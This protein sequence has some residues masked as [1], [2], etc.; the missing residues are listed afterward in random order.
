MSTASLT[1]ITDIVTSND[2][3]S[4]SFSVYQL[5]VNKRPDRQCVSWALSCKMY[6]VQST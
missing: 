1:W 2:S 5:P 3:L 6:N 4:Y